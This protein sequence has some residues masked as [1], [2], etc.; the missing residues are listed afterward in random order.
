ML[1][2]AGK[3]VQPPKLNGIARQRSPMKKVMS[4]IML[5][6]WNTTQNRDVMNSTLN[7]LDITLSKFMLCLDR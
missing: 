4:Q 7:E 3:Y 1:F 6:N 5:Y 2:L